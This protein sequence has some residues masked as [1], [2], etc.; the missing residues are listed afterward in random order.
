MKNVNPTHTLAWKALE[1]HFAV[2]KDTEM[3]NT[4]LSRSITL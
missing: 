3:K 2:M 4:V 1:D